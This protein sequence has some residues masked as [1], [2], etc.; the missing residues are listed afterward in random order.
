MRNGNADV[1]EA[2]KW[3][4]NEEVAQYFRLFI[5]DRF[6]VWAI[7][8]HSSHAI[9]VESLGGWSRRTAPAFIIRWY[10]ALGAAL[11]TKMRMFK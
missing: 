5:C 9:F 11:T 2:G 1:D 4:L 10:G 3:R 6:S 7:A 8:A